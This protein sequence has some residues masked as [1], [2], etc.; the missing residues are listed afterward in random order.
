MAEPITPRALAK[1][2]GVSDRAIRQFCRDQGWQSV[3]YARWV[4][5]EEQASAVRARFG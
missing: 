5:T 1:Q 4:L 3:P 2:L